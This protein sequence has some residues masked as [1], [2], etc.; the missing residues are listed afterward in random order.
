SR[1]RNRHH[2]SLD[3]QG[4][5]GLRNDAAAEFLY[6][7][8]AVQAIRTINEALNE[9]GEEDCHEYARH[10]DQYARQVQSDKRVSEKR[11]EKKERRKYPHPD[12]EYLPTQLDSCSRWFAK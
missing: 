12:S 8:G 9:L 11:G 5:L 1:T 2:N 10:I 4:W 7:Y 3:A 6:Y